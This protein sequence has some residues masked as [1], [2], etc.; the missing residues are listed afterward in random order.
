M[1]KKQAVR[2]W[3]VLIWLK[4]RAVVKTAIGLRVT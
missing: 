3:A 2:M 1:L 4:L